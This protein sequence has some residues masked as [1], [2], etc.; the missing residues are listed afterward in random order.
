MCGVS[1]CV[2]ACVCLSLN[3]CVFF[4][5]LCLSL[6]GSKCLQICEGV[7]SSLSFYGCVF[8]YEFLCV[9]ICLPD[10]AGGC[11]SSSYSNWGQVF[12]SVPDFVRE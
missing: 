10:S 9:R 5:Y 7:Y 11:P 1:F 2:F 12:T 6:F 3:S 4:V 8:M